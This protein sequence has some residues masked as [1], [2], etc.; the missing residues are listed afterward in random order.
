MNTEINLDYYYLLFHILLVAGVGVVVILRDW[1]GVA[2][3]S[4]RTS[5]N[6]SIQQFKNYLPL[7]MGSKAD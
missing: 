5:Y 2:T 4:S 6:M 7:A 3:G 1:H